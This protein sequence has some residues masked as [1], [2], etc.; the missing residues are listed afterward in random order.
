[1]SVAASLA[2]VLPAAAFS[3]ATRARGWT[4]PP[5]LAEAPAPEAVV[6]PE[7][8]E[9][10]AATMR[11]AAASGVGVLPVASGRRLR[12][13]QLD[14]PYVVLSSERLAGIEM[15]E[16]ADLTVTARA[17]T[18]LSLLG[19]ELGAHGQWLPFDPPHVEDRSLGGLVAAGESGPIW[20]GYGEL[21]NHV[22]GATVVTGEG[23][24]LRLGGRVVKNVAG[25]DLLRAVVGSRGRLGVITSVCMRA[26]PRPAED[27][28][29][30]LADEDPLAL[31]SAARGVG[32]A[33][34]MPVSSV[35]A[36]PA[37]PLGTGAALLVRLHGS[38]AAVAADRRA[39]ERHA[40]VEFDLAVRAA[41]LRRWAGAHASTGQVL[42]ARVLASRLGAAIETAY[43]MLASGAGGPADSERGAL[44]LA[45]DTYRAEL[46]IAAAAFEP[47]AVARFREA[48]ES[49]G[50]V[51]T[52]VGSPGCS[53]A[54]RPHEIELVRGI[55]RVFD[56]GGTLWPC[57]T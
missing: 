47:A 40:G 38:S 20:M 13:A 2:D 52:V 9:E 21:R 42:L 43:R 17:G 55:E 7:S 4:P 18:R 32:T 45:A 53:T 33:P 31:V 46:R 6:R 50:G 23:R 5:V 10:V 49:F 1:M 56:P 51:L 11:W 19:E 29:L 41:D 44:E 36:A 35:I 26:F 30:V 25:F 54:P 22:L 16:P 3:E 28:L 12:G 14:R 8:T 37:R 34:V 27:A 15:Y 48:I 39:L 24:V 57:R